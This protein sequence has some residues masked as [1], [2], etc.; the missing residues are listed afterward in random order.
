MKLPS[1]V[2]LGSEGCVDSN[3]IEAANQSSLLSLGVCDPVNQ[4]SLLQVQPGINQRISGIVFDHANF[5]RPSQAITSTVGPADNLTWQFNI[6]SSGLLIEG[7]SFLNIAEYDK[8]PPPKC[9]H[10]NG[11]QGYSAIGLSGCVGCVIRGNYVPHSGGD[12]L[13]FNSGEY[14]V[15]ENTVENSGDGCIA[16]NNNAF[17]TVANNILRRCNLG[18]GSGPSGG[19]N[20]PCPPTGC[21]QPC[22]N[23]RGTGPDTNSTPFVVTGNLIEDCDYGMLLGW[24]GYKGRLGPMNTV[25]S[26]NVIRRARQSAVQYQ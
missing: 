1:G 3:A 17:G 25:I 21:S 19:C 2:K 8:C 18:I 11:M 24:F 20:L 22:G 23:P 15:T 9:Q 6:G 10:T 4:V 26:S 14:I 5:T 13:N 12:A 16:M 7:C